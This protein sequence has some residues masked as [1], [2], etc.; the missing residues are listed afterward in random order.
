MADCAAASNDNEIDVNLRS[1]EDIALRALA[2]AT[3]LRRVVL[4]SDASLDAEPELFDLRQWSREEG[5]LPSFTP[6]E[7]ALLATPL[8][9]ADAEEVASIAWQSPGL[10]V[11]LWTIGW[12][13]SG[14]EANQAVY[15][16][17]TTAS[18]ALNDLP[19]PWDP[20]TP[21]IV[22]AQLREEGEITRERER[23]EIWH[24]LVG[25]EIL[26]RQS[27]SADRAELEDA[28]GEVIAEAAASGLFKN[29]RTT[30]SPR[31]LAAASASDLKDLSV[32]TAERLRALNWVCGFGTDWD[33]TPLDV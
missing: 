17:G 29:A 8:G 12:N 21:W 31:S 5:L 23:A 4:E 15:V 33:S 6:H 13:V 16:V 10:Q 25:T 3:V 28:M 22:S 19:S 27:L 24:W 7:A 26:W 14:A 32:V 18:P 20:V 2:L 30:K 11:L 9:E 1:A